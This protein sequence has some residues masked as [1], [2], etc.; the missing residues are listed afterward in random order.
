MSLELWCLFFAAI[1]HV[2]TKVPL[3]KAQNQES[4]GYDNHNPRVQQAA[5]KGW[6]V[7]ALAAHQ[8]QI[9][10]FPLFA[11]GVLAATA[12][13]VGSVLVGYLAVL[14][15]ISR[16]A[17]FYLYLKDVATARSLTWLVSFGTSAALIC[18]PAWGL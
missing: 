16:L 8:N 10:S 2:V 1:L 15:L 17:F 7:R 3:I 14:H 5:L 4:G 18:S 6:G 11:A 9:E 13:N 12:S